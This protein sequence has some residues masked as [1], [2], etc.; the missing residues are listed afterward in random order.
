MINRPNR[1]RCGVAALACL[2]GLATGAEWPSIIQQHDPRTESHPH[3]HPPVDVAEQEL[4]IQLAI[5]LDTSGSMEGLIRQ[6]QAQLWSIVNE[7]G[8]A[9]CGTR[10]PRV[11]VALYQYG[12]DDLPASEGFV[13]CLTPFT[14]DLDH[15]GAILFSLG[16]NGGSEYCGWVAR[17][18]ARQLDWNEDA[19]MRLL[20]VAGNEPF[21]QGPVDY[22]V[23]AGELLAQKVLMNTIHCGD[24][25][26]GVRTM[27]QDAAVLTGGHYS[28]IDHNAEPVMYHS[29]YDDRIGSL[30]AELNATYLAYGARETRAANAMRQQ[31]VDAAAEALAPAALAD[32]AVAKSSASYSADGWDLIDAVESQAVRL[33]DLDEAEL[34]EQLQGLETAEQLA[35]LAETASRRQAIQA[36]IQELALKRQAH[37]EQ[38]RA[39]DQ[40]PQ[41]L[42]QAL[43]EALRTQ[44]EQHG[45]S[46]E[47]AEQNNDETSG[48]AE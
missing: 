28:V 20:I 44:A 37:I 5:A 10:A 39:A 43:F 15:V 38:Q 45:L 18:A 6:A 27:W 26:E 19:A 13:S 25:H 2:A 7:L 22:R 47:A 1:L 46:Y 12:C 14:S 17:S 21:T 31:R 3:V 16:T 30:N 34:P 35:L 24:Y 23:S 40:G 41:T 4:V 33:Q 8:R 32:R 9:R 29:P 48:N 36:E 42:D 11:E